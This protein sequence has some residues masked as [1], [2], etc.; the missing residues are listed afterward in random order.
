MQN[1]LIV[2]FTTLVLLSLLITSAGTATAY[3]QAEPQGTP[4]A[5]PPYEEGLLKE[6]AFLDALPPECIKSYK[7]AARDA[8]PLAAAAADVETT[9]TGG[10][11]SFGYTYD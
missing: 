4:P 7:E 10:P 8:Q 2:L 6:K 3:A 1:K 11:D 9:A 5:C